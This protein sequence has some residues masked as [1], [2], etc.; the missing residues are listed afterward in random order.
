[1]ARRDGLRKSLALVSGGVLV[2]AFVLYR[3]GVGAS[4]MSGSKST[5][6]FVGSSI[7]PSNPPAGKPAPANPPGSQAGRLNPF[8]PVPPGE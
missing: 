3:S 7:A 2:A 8:A 5:F 6:I 4:S 1:M